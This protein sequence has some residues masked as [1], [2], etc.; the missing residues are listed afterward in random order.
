MIAKSTT[1][2]VICGPVLAVFLVGTLAIGAWR[3]PPADADHKDDGPHADYLWPELPEGNPVGPVSGFEMNSRTTNALTIPT[4]LWGCVNPC[5]KWAYAYVGAIN[6]WN[7]SISPL[8]GFNPFTDGTQAG[9]IDYEAVDTTKCDFGAHGCVRHW[10]PAT[11]SGLISMYAK[12]FSDTPHRVSDSMH[13]FGH[14]LANPNHHTGCISIMEECLGTAVTADDI[15]DYQAAYGVLDTADAV[16]TYVGFGQLV[17]YF[18]GGY[19]FGNGQTVHQEFEYVFDRST[20]GLNG[21]Y[22][23]YA[24]T[25]RRVDNTDNTNPESYAVNGLPAGNSQWCFKTRGHAKGVKAGS[26]GEW[27]PFSKRDCIARSG[28][29]T[30]VFVTSDRNYNALFRVSNF[31]GAAIVNVQLR[32]S[33]PPGNQICSWASIPD[34]T[35]SS[36]CGYA[37][38]SSGSLDVWYN[39]AWVRQGTIE[40]DQ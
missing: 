34:N 28:G 7:G 9:Y 24:A 30:G 15:G 1:R 36:T 16:Y 4:R 8:S 27:G 2:H 39:N 26:S 18:E 13:E 25:G 6:N 11:P 40:Y 21:T 14:V 35:V 20:G 31:S 33:P 23:F 12:K 19:N 32:T 37:T 22:S 5:S 10:N 17:H 38:G 3:A 29:G